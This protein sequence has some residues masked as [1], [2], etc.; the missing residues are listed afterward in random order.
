MPSLAFRGIDSG[1]LNG[2]DN[3]K[4][5][6]AQGNQAAGKKGSLARTLPWFFVLTSEGILKG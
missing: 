1:H 3:Q 2:G 6:G 4:H 5:K